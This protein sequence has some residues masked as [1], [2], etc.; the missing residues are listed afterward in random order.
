MAVPAMA[1]FAAQRG[2]ET[3]IKWNEAFQA[4]AQAQL[5]SG[6]LQMQMEEIQLRTDMQIRNIYKTSEKVQSAQTAAFTAGGVEISGS[7]MSVISDT[8]NNAAEAA[9]IRQREANYDLL[10]TG[11]EKYKYDQMG[12][13]ET[14]MLKLATATIG[15]AKDFASDMKGRKLKGIGEDSADTAMEEDSLGDEDAIDLDYF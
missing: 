4:Q 5:Q 13:N 2:A 8:I 1:M 15:G 10:S 7:A 3:A 6:A 12:S 14:L 9:Y 11:M